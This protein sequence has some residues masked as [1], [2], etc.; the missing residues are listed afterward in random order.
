VKLGHDNPIWI[1]L[2]GSSITFSNCFCFLSYLQNSW[3]WSGQHSP[4]GQINALFLHLLK[5]HFHATSA[6]LSSQENWFGSAPYCASA[7]NC[8]HHQQSKSLL[9]LWR[10]MLSWITDI[11]QNDYMGTFQKFTGI[12]SIYDHVKRTNCQGKQI[13]T[14]NPLTKR[15]L[16]GIGCKS[17]CL[18]IW[19]I[20]VLHAFDQFFILG[21]QPHHTDKCL[22]KLGCTFLSRAWFF[23]NFTNQ[24]TQYIYL[25][26]IFFIL[27]I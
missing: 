27:F 21:T 1:I 25:Y 15:T 8:L 18:L 12:K 9:V 2:C 14:S 4:L 10:R 22:Q 19:R 24:Y 13:T 7:T 20:Y 26:V 16:C 6:L 23:K 3:P 11:H 17:K 5:P